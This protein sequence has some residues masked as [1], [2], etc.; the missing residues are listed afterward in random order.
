MLRSYVFRCSYIG[1]LSRVLRPFLY[2]YSS[3]VFEVMTYEMC[4]KV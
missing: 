4:Y 3:K 1:I 2:G